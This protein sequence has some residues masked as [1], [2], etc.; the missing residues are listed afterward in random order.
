MN[1][2]VATDRVIDKKV[3]VTYRHES[4][5]NFLAQESIDPGLHSIWEGGLPIDC[6]FAPR[7]SAT[8]VVVL[9]G[10][11]TPSITLPWLSGTSILAGMEVSRLSISDPSLYLGGGLTSAYYAGNYHQPDLQTHLVKIVAKAAESA[12][13][14]NIVFLGGSSGGFASL[15]LSAHFPQ[16]TAVVFNPQTNLYVHTE[17]PIQAWLSAAWEVNSLEELP[18]SVEVD[19]ISQYASGFTHRVIYMQN[20][21]DHHH[22]R[23]FLPFLRS[24]GPGDLQYL[25]HDEAQGHA[26]PPKEMI[27]SAVESACSLPHGDLVKGFSR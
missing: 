2:F 6:I 7:V 16:C 10:A 11:T 18:G 9:N 25:V 26:P 12:R 14:E 3:H 22:N 4:V 1:N 17:G 8:L 20:I 27:R 21:T 19:L 15:A 23:H 13:A 24:A 5:S